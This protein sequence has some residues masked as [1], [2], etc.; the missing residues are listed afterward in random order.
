MGDNT[1]PNAKDDC[2]IIE[3]GAHGQQFVSSRNVVK[4]GSNNGSNKKSMMVRLTVAD[5]KMN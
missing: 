4:I 5:E 2:K 1:E 3:R